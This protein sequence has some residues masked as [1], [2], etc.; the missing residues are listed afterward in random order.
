M[1]VMKNIV[2]EVLE[3]H[4]EGYSVNEIAE[5]MGQNQVDVGFIVTEFTLGTDFEVPE[6][7]VQ[8]QDVEFEDVPF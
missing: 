5:R 8:F 2:I 6:Q 7:K 4:D 3:L 1:G